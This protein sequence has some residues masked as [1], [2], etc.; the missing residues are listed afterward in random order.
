MAPLLTLVFPPA[1]AVPVL[2]LLSLSASAR[3]V[4]EVWSEVHWKRVA[5]VGVP[6]VLTIPIGVHFLTGLDGEVVRRAVSGMVLCLV[7]LLA[8]GVRYPGAD[9]LRILVPTG[10][11]SGVLS[12]IGG[13]GGPP[14]VLA[15]LSID[16]PAA[17]TRADLIAYFAIV[18]IAAVGTFL[19]S[20]NLGFDQLWLYLAAAPPFLLA[21]HL[22]SNMFRGNS[23]RNYRPLSLAFLALV[24]LVG[25]LWP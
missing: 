6:A 20:G 4:P 11:V 9:R 21:I 7:G 19:A 2:L 1:V 3:L 16:E 10:A 15:F 14:V 8:T 24:A 22:G 18:Q 17:N 25:L 23:G 12:G 5:R 13:V